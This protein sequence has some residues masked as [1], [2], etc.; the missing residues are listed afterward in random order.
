MFAVCR[1][2]FTTNMYLP[3]WGDELLSAAFSRLYPGCPYVHCHRSSNEELMEN[4]RNEC[5]PEL[6]PP[7]GLVP[8][9]GRDLE[10]AHVVSLSTFLRKFHLASHS[11]TGCESVKAW[12]PETVGGFIRSLAAWEAVLLTSLEILLS[13][14]VRWED[15]TSI[16]LECDSF[17]SVWSACGN[18]DWCSSSKKCYAWWWEPEAI[19]ESIV[20]LPGQ[21]R[22][23]GPTPDELE[24]EWCHDPYASLHAPVH[25]VPHGNSQVHSMDCNNTFFSCAWF[26]TGLHLFNCLC[27][28]S[29][30]FQVVGQHH[31]V[32]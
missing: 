25:K 24:L 6:Q 21:L 22:I 27:R 28:P 14:R 16:P 12:S 8:V 15:S 1:N 19:N 11:S 10:S 26:F 2:H 13:R 5:L 29:F 30:A 20:A 31:G 3:M 7:S 23:F 9:W 17:P 32:K 4:N 18:C